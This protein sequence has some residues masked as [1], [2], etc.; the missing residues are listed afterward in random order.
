MTKRTD[1]IS[2]NEVALHKSEESCW[3]VLEGKVL[4]VTHYL[5]EHPGGVNKIMHVAGQ[6][7]TKAFR[8][9]KHSIDAF[10]T[11]EKFVIGTLE[12]KR[13]AL[14]IVLALIAVALG[15]YFAIN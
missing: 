10:Q 5:E 1:P 4:D 2:L 9:A 3:I 15:V 14:F 11:S 7:A 8:D 13:N 6:D 12:K